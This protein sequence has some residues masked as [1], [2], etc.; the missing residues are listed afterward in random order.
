[1]GWIMETV[2]CEKCESIDVKYRKFNLWLYERRIVKCCK[3]GHR[4][5]DHYYREGVIFDLLFSPHQIRNVWAPI[6]KGR[7]QYKKVPE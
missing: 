3:C 6:G 4:Y 1:M 5:G 2:C 7:L